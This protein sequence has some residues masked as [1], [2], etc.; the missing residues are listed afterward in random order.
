MK[1]IKL[2]NL[3]LS[4]SIRTI[5]VIRVLPFLIILPSKH[6]FFIK[7]LYFF[8]FLKKKHYYCLRNHKQYKIINDFKKIFF[9]FK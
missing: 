1:S 4:V 5:R 7:Y 2:S 9:Y 8:G 3:Y 6:H